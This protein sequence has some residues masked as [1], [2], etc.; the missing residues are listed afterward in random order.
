MTGGAQVKHGRIEAN[1][2]CAMR[3]SPSPAGFVERM[4]KTSEGVLAR[5]LQTELETLQPSTIT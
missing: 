1:H 4:G 5:V 3:R 2:V